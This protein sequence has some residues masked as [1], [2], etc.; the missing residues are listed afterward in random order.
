MLT[1]SEYYG[2]SFL[3]LRSKDSAAAVLST[4]MTGVIATYLKWMEKHLLNNMYV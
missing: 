2:Q 3:R 1:L 4:D